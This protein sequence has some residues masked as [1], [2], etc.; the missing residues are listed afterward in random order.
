MKTCPNCGAVTNNDNA[1][2]CN[3]CGSEFKDEKYCPSCGRPIQNTSARFC[4]FCGTSLENE[5][6]SS[7]VEKVQMYL[8]G[9]DT[10]INDI[11]TEGFQIAKREV[12]GR[13]GNS[14]LAEDIAQETMLTFFEKADT[15]EKAG[16]FKA[17]VRTIA[18][19]KMKDY[20]KSAEQ[21]HNQSLDAMTYGEEDDIQ[22]D[23][24]D[25]RGTY[26]PDV[27]MSDKARDEIVKEVLNTLSDEQKTIALL[28]YYNDMSLREI[29]EEMGIEMS[30]VQGRFQL[31]KKNIKNE[32]TTIQN[33]DD[34]K[35][36]NITGAT[37]IPFF[38]YLLK[39]SKDTSFTKYTAGITK[40][41]V[42]ERV[43]TKTTEK[44]T[45]KVI[46]KT[47]PK[48]SE[49]VI[50]HT[51]GTATT[52]STATAVTTG[53]SVGTKIAIGAA[54]AVAAA[55]GGYVAVNKITSRNRG[56][57]AG[58]ANSGVQIVDSIAEQQSLSVQYDIESK[59][60]YVNTSDE[61]YGTTDDFLSYKESSEEDVLWMYHAESITIHVTG[62]EEEARSKI[63]EWSAKN[64]ENFLSE[65]E[66]NF[67]TYVDMWPSETISNQ[68]TYGNYD[69]NAYCWYEQSYTTTRLNSSVFSFIES[70]NWYGGGPHGS[71]ESFGHNFDLNTGEYL[72]IEDV[73]TDY[74]E[75]KSYATQLVISK[76]EE[77]Y[78]DMLSTTDGWNYI[79][80]VNDMWTKDEGPNWY[81]TEDGIVFYFNPYELG[82]YAMTSGGN[83]A[84]L[85]YSEL[86]QYLKEEY[87]SE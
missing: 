13:S 48:A 85:S 56:S 83:Q 33:R 54:I 65:V 20:F 66:M 41:V 15:M 71:V 17:F 40:A 29:S 3:A 51:A 7:I 18:S 31:A 9:E 59:D 14:T 37:A 25:E 74:E 10:Y 87:K 79:E 52:T 45:E 27:Q 81:F 63:E 64:K 22:Y 34:I 68:S 55:G 53:V 47:L 24:A 57:D 80:V 58:N 86:S 28:Y 8:D 67:Q 39:T 38:M 76:L 26:R 19:N 5:D 21:K 50:A 70:Q 60:W 78:G 62:I 16:N 69:E 77:Q 72:S 82:S 12:N 6:T 23:Q 84:L 61:S 2:F 30:T 32:I 44:A 46:A 75:F 43:I 42:K 49:R 4:L 36:Y 35:L 73:V 11:Y 1:R